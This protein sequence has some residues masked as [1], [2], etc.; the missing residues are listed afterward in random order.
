MANLAISA[1]VRLNRVIRGFLLLLISAEFALAFSAK[2]QAIDEFHRSLYASRLVPASLTET[3]AISMILAEAIV[4]IGLLIPHTRW[5]AA[6][7]ALF[8]S[9]LFLCYG[10]WRVVIGIQ[11]PCHC[12]GLILSFGPLAALAMAFFTF[13]ATAFLYLLISTDYRGATNEDFVLGFSRN[14]N[15]SRIVR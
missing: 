13:G 4:S 7:P 14:R 8:L 3:V 5:M 1:S 10:I 2:F 15:P 9:S 12:F 11:T 6:N